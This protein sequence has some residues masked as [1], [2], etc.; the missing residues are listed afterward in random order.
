MKFVKYF[1]V[2]VFFLSFTSATCSS[3]QININTASLSDLDKLSGIGPVYAQAIADARL[4]SSIDKLVDV[5]GIG[6]ATLEK[7]KSQ[8]LACVENEEETTTEEENT[9]KEETIESKDEKTSSKTIKTIAVVPQLSTPEPS[10]SI[11]N[12][13]NAQQEETIVYE[14]KGEKVN[15]YLLTGFCV[16]LIGIIFLLIRK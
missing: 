15:K 4:F 3:N 8:G 2:L 11:I 12:L 14:S 13:N 9:I 5:K 1:L 6:P 7:I 10:E 16:F